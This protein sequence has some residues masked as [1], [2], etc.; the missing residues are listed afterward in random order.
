M[1]TFTKVRILVR[2]PIAISI[3]KHCLICIPFIKVR[4]LPSNEINKVSLLQRLALIF[5]F[6]TWCCTFVDCHISSFIGHIAFPILSICSVFSILESESQIIIVGYKQI[7]W[8][9]CNIDINRISIASWRYNIWNINKIGLIM[10]IY[11]STRV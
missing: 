11:R 1:R 2:G 7:D 5:V 8:I 6:I 3:S 9:S 4:A 10:K